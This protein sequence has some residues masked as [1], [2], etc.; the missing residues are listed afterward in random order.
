MTIHKLMKSPGMIFTTTAVMVV[1]SLLFTSLPVNSSAQSQLES[2]DLKP[3]EEQENVSRDIARQ[4]QYAHY[5]SL[6]I[7]G[8]VSSQVL[9]NYLKAL[10]PQKL[11]LT[12]EDVEA[13]EAYRFRLDGA[14]K[15]GQLEPAFQIYKTYQERMDSQ[16]TYILKLLEQ[17][18][19]KL[20][21]DGDDTL[22]IDR[23]DAPWGKNSREI[24]QLWDKRIRSAVL[25]QRLTGKTDKE[26]LSSLIKRYEGQKKRAS[27][28]RSEDVFQTY[29]NALTNTYDPHTQYFSPRNSE[30]FNINMSLSLEGIGAVLQSDNEF[31]KVVRLVPAGPAEKNGLLQPADRIIGVG[32]G[33]SG[34]IVNVNGWRLEEVVDLIRGPKQTTVRLEVIPAKSSDENKT[35]VVNIVRDKV[36]LEDQ[37]AQS[38]II[39][40]QRGTHTY[41]LGVIYI[42]TFYADFRA[43]QAGDSDARSTT[44]DV[45]QLI[46]KLTREGIDG[47]IIDLRNNGGGALQEAISLTGLFIERGPT[48]QV[49]TADDRVR[50]Y[51]DPD[52]GVSYTGPLA[53][54]V[55]R[56]SASAS[57][58]FAA[59]IQDYGRG[60]IVG[61]QT[62]GKG[63]VQS[64]RTLS[65]G[66]L[67]ITEAKFYRISGGSTQHKGV[68]PDLEIPSAINKLEIGED[69]LP[70]ALPWDQIAPVAFRSFAGFGKSL[71]DIADKHKIR[72]EQHPEYQ[73]LLKEIAYI[74]SLRNQTEMS[75]NE[76]LRRIEL[77][78]V[79]Q[80]ELDVINAKRAA[81]GKDAFKTYDAFEVWQ[82]EQ[83]AKQEKHELI[84]FF[85]KETAEVLIDSLGVQAQLATH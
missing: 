70:S 78:T 31:T 4:L 44:Q 71:S 11:Y 66:Q 16:L 51:D 58:I 61:E 19:D 23:S 33:E 57:E 15:T 30:N 21:F 39:R 1:F 82:E 56:M 77:E 67:K 25:S 7:D 80:A 35:R 48:V 55:N 42:P 64:V 12:A 36:K 84:D 81:E 3:T 63:T 60:I 26:I 18:L 40:M 27:Q 34:E 32:Q 45:K 22:L 46:D 59:A 79:R 68:I 62:F 85:T 14:L 24:N 13:F 49:R 75:L 83:A 41:S 38:D 20:V 76:S 5:R 2:T 28:A 37:S 9:D 73:A 69:A 50:V 17:G 72:M 53:V 74:A 8:G 54:L 10:D 6:K 43:L 29:M 47:L 52:S 65:H